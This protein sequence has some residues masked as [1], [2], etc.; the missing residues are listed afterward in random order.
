MAVMGSHRALPSRAEL[1]RATRTTRFR[2]AL[3]TMRPTK[4][5]LILLTGVVLAIAAVAA[6]AANAASR[7]SL[8][9]SHH[10]TSATAGSQHGSHHGQAGGSNASNAG[11]AGGMAA[12]PASPG[13][14]P[15]AA[16]PTRAGM[17]EQRPLLPKPT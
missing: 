13:P 5:L 11:Q 17:A 9:S 2:S 3:P 8:S 16:S 15:V 7:R 10:V 4:K 6:F 12:V 1:A 14:S